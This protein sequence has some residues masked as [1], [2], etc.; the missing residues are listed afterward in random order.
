MRV[1]HI[2]QGNISTSNKEYPPSSL[3][4]TQRRGMREHHGWKF[5][6]TYDNRKKKRHNAFEEDNNSLN[7]AEDIKA[8]FFK[9]LN[10]TCGILQKLNP[11]FQNNELG[12]MTSHSSHHVMQPHRA[13]VI[14]FQPYT[15]PNRRCSLQV[16]QR[17]TEE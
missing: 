16:A 2:L 3:T 6:L 11:D 1:P 10:C 5:P 4:H 17:L 9:S 12:T 7:K 15:S 13:D 8:F 14:N